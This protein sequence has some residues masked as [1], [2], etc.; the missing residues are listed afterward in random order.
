MSFHIISQEWFTVL[1]PFYMKLQKCFAHFRSNCTI[2]DVLLV[3]EI[4]YSEASK[5]TDRIMIVSHIHVENIPDLG[6]WKHEYQQNQWS[7]TLKMHGEHRKSYVSWC[8]QYKTPWVVCDWKSP[9]KIQRSP[10]LHLQRWNLKCWAIKRLQ[11]IVLLAIMSKR[12][13]WWLA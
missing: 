2:I 13:S 6:S 8:H 10:A 9:P 3:N 1:F 5:W 11:K 7:R 12:L 4:S